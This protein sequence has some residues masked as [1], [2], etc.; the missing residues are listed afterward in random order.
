MPATDRARSDKVTRPAPP[1]EIL[2]LIDKSGDCVPPFDGGDADIWAAVRALPDQQCDAVLL[3]YAEDMSHAEAA[4]VMGIS[5][6][7]VSWHLHAAR[8]TLKTRLQAAE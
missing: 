7:T 2:A 4:D 1:D 3:V 5:E 6:K 8:K